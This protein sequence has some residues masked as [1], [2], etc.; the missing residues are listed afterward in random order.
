MWNWHQ[1]KI[2]NARISRNNAFGL[3]IQKVL[4]QNLYFWS[5]VRNL[6]FAKT[7]H[8]KVE[9][10]LKVNDEIEGRTKK[11]SLLMLQVVPFIAIYLILV[12]TKCFIF[13]QRKWKENLSVV[14]CCRCISIGKCFFPL[15]LVCLIVYVF[16]SF[17]QP[18]LNSFQ[19]Q[20][21]KK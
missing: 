3:H 18:W 21:I 2:W 19:D 1:S 15:A 7:N 14:V 13:F 11:F 4:I 10:T 9:R 17:D 8:Q 16:Q 5:A 12:S 6:Q 20:Q